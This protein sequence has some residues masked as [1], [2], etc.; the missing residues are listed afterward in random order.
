MAARKSIDSFL[1]FV[2]RKI[3]LV[4]NSETLELSL[5]FD[6]N[7][8]CK[9]S[10]QLVSW[11]T[12]FCEKQ[13]ITTKISKEYMILWRILQIYWFLGDNKYFT[14]RSERF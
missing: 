7:I 3:I 1:A 8:V 4:R 10:V 12:H 9:E 6:N 14:F 2:V 13:I 5:T 11:A